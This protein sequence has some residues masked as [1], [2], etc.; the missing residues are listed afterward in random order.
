MTPTQRVDIERGYVSVALVAPFWRYAVGP[1][2]G[3]SPAVPFYTLK[4]ARAFY[5]EAKRD[6]PWAGVVLY[7]RSGWGVIEPIKEYKP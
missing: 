3:H 7:R 6:L 5:E 4:G 1:A 2:S